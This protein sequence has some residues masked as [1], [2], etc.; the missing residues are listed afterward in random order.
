MIPGEKIGCFQYNLPHDFVPVLFP[1]KY[2]SSAALISVNAGSIISFKELKTRYYPAELI[3][4]KH[5][6]K[7]RFNLIILNHIYS[8][9]KKVY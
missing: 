8:F 7:V 6:R 2:L 5:S 4:M 9:D 3:Q 1:E